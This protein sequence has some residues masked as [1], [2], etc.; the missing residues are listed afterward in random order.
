MP[1]AYCRNCNN[2]IRTRK[3]MLEPCDCGEDNIGEEE[4]VILRLDLI[5][6]RLDE[7]EKLI[8]P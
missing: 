7:L 4:K 3:E 8:M 5:E 6:E 1:W 2:E